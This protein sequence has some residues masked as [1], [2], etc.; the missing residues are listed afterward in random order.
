MCAG[1]YEVFR[2]VD[3]I[4]STAGSTRWIGPE[5]AQAMAVKLA[6]NHMILGMGELLAEVFR[7]LHASGVAPSDAKAA[8]TDEMLPRVLA[9]YAERLSADLDGPRPAASAIGRKD[10]A[11]LL[12]AAHGLNVELGLANCLARLK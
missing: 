5:P 6:G 3:P 8:S 7:F 10:N 9:G 1:A 4:L 12:D 11:L 2:L